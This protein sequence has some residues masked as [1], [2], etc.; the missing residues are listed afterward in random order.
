[1]A[2]KII[3]L[4]FFVFMAL[5]AQAQTVSEMQ[6]ELR[7]LGMKLE[8]YTA[9]TTPLKEKKAYVEKILDLRAKLEKLEKERSAA[10]AASGEDGGPVERNAPL[11]VLSEV[12]YDGEKGEAYGYDGYTV[13]HCISRDCD[14][15]GRMLRVLKFADYPRTIRLGE[16]FSV[17]VSNRTRNRFP[18]Y[19]NN[20]RVDSGHREAQMP[21]HLFVSFNDRMN[22][23]TEGTKSLAPYC[24]QLTKKKWLWKEGYSAWSNEETLKATYRLELDKI[25]YLSGKN[26]MPQYYNY[27]V[28]EAVTSGVFKDGAPKGKTF[29]IGPF[30]R[31]ERFDKDGYYLG[32]LDQGDLL[33][34]RLGSELYPMALVYRLAKAGDKPPALAAVQPPEDMALTP[35]EIMEAVAAADRGD[36]NAGKSLQDMINP[37]SPDVSE[38]IMQWMMFA[39]PPENATEGASFKYEEWGRVYGRTANGAV[40]E[41]PDRL[42]DGAGSQTYGQYL[43]ARAGKMDS[44]NH[45]TLKEY[46][47][48]KGKNIEAC[49]GRYKAPAKQ[50]A[51]KPEPVKTVKKAEPPKAAPVAKAPVA[52]P[53]KPKPGLKMNA[54]NLQSF[55][56]KAFDTR[57]YVLMAEYTMAYYPSKSN[58]KVTTMSD[59]NGEA[60]ATS[61]DFKLPGAK[62]ASGT[63]AI[64]WARGNQGAK[65]IKKYLKDFTSGYNGYGTTYYKYESP[66]RHAF[67]FMSTPEKKTKEQLRFL[68]E[69]ALR[70]IEPYALPK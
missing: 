9:D 13:D 14:K 32:D 61:R 4:L 33:T 66:D 65:N 46:I 18:E 20:C 39:E 11:L 1:M 67:I 35:E 7:S 31:N 59:S 15:Y 23:E 19:H 43:W 45:C 49:K 16:S 70:Y 60:F 27:V 34:I 26:P 52:A 53:V 36:A 64:Y 5:P 48:K 50:E 25:D 56:L 24:F 42:P 69:A 55:S 6:E 21:A 29:K 38:L 54:S 8:Y 3:L 41:K 2:R 30:S 28:E 57:P 58:G 51:K 63:L 44:V 22:I 37:D 10:A 62:N 40:I 47:E 68:A 12:R 17:T